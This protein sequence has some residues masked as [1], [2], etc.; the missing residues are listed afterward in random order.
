[1]RKWGRDIIAMSKVYFDQVGEEISEEFIALLLQSLIDEYKLLRN[2]PVSY[3]EDQIEDDVERY[4]DGRK[5][6]IALSVMPQVYGK[7]GAEGL[8]SLTDAGTT[9]NWS[10]VHHLADVVPICE[11]I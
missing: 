1:M 11:V 4:F 9:R 3:T 8:A 7:I 6:N 2:Y 10:G 5:T